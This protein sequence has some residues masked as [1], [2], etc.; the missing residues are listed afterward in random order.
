MEIL[1]YFKL[2]DL[3]KKRESY[4]LMKQEESKFTALFLAAPLA[5]FLKD[6]FVELEKALLQHFKSLKM[7]KN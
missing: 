3:K 2:L 6:D 7:E 1:E 5:L 4:A